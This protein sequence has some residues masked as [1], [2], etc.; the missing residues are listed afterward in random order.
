MIKEEADEVGKKSVKLLERRGWVVW[1]CH[2]LN[3]DKI[4][5]VESR[6][7][8]H[9]TKYP[10]YTLGELKVLCESAGF[11]LVHEAVKQGFTVETE[12]I[13]D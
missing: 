13:L 9:P 10:V 3:D 7:N 12:S 8:S 2:E 5:I 11:K 6:L 4:T 1:K